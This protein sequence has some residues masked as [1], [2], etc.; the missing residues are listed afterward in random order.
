[1]RR[2][3]P[4]VLRM[5]VKGNPSTSRSIQVLKVSCRFVN[6]GAGT[7]PLHETKLS[8]CGYHHV[9]A[10]DDKLHELGA[11]ILGVEADAML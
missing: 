1:M 10:G 6:I 8:M 3:V 2:S 9:A 4:W 7:Y 11:R 5:C